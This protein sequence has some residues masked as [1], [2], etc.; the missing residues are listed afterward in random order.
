MWFQKARSSRNGTCVP[1]DIIFS[2]GSDSTR[3]FIDIPKYNMLDLDAAQAIASP[4]S[5]LMTL[6]FLLI[7]LTDQSRPDIGPNGAV[8]NKKSVPIGAVC[9]PPPVL[10]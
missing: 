10:C 6:L 2:N 8:E 7:D 5:T 1:V 9:C 4:Y 3:A